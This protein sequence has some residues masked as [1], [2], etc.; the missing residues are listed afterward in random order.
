MSA[1]IDYFKQIARGSNV[2]KDV[3]EKR[4]REFL[5]FIYKLKA[6]DSERLKE[7]IQLRFDYLVGAKIL[8]GYNA[9]LDYQELKEQYDKLCIL[10]TEKKKELN[11]KARL[12]SE[13]TNPY[14]NLSV[15]QNADK[16]RID[17][18]YNAQIENLNKNLEKEELKTY[19]DLENIVTLYAYYLLFTEAREIL[20]DKVKRRRVDEDI[21]L[22]FNPNQEF[23]HAD[24][25]ISNLKYIPSSGKKV[26]YEMKNKYGDI[27]IFEHT[28]NLEYGQFGK[29]HPLFQ[30]RTTLQKYKIHKIYNSMQDT[31]GNIPEKDFEIFTYLNINQMSLDENFTAAHSNILFS[32]VNLEEAIKHN[33]GY[34][35]EVEY[36]DGKIVVV[37][38]QDKLS[39]CK[40]Y[41][42]QNN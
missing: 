10:A 22:G 8:E 41:K 36:S 27:V 32:D 31:N 4:Y 26:S 12:R 38:A 2:T 17:N 14:R 1:Y 40:E 18:S 3:L 39:A 34:V 25:T 16:Y 37:H 20:L 30:D 15:P 5:N 23:S 9:G 35:G 7:L 24:I 11:N 13:K 6:S 33:G 19:K 28:G 29:K 21:S 42:K